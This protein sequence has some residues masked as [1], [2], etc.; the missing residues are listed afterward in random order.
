MSSWRSPDGMG[1][2]TATSHVGVKL[3]GGSQLINLLKGALLHQ[4]ESKVRRAMSKGAAPIIS[5]AKRLAAKATYYQN[6]GVLVDSI[7]VLRRF[8]RDPLG[9]YVG[10]IYKRKRN[11]RQV[12]S[13]GKPKGEFGNAW[14]AHFVEYGTN[15]HNLGYKGKYVSAK[16]AQHK[17]SKPMPYMAPA[18]ETMGNKALNAIMDELD[19]IIVD[20]L[21]KG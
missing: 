5:E 11:K 7:K 1:Y 21:M 18:Y 16:G 14:Y 6:T 17:G 3:E 2:R 10:P 19:K 4:P 13:G 12:D 20:A 9:I 8:N 15:P